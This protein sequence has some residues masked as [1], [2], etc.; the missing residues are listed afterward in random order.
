[1]S[2]MWQG[3]IAYFGAAALQLSHLESLILSRNR[4][5]TGS[6]DKLFCQP[7]RR[8]LTYLDVSFNNINGTI[9]SCLLGPGTSMAIVLCMPCQFQVGGVGERSL[10]FAGTS[11]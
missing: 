6:L 1:M 3:D 2:F 4:Y 5:L 8:S 7:V 9:P 10:H 11:C